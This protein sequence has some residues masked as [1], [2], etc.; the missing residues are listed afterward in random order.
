M[1]FFRAILLGTILISLL[2]KRLN[3]PNLSVRINQTAI[4]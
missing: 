4:L 1:L 3:D 2:S